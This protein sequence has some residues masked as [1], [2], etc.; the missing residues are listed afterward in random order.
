MQGMIGS[1]NIV[2]KMTKSR[3]SFYRQYLLEDIGEDSSSDEG[4]VEKLINDEIRLIGMRRHLRKKRHRIIFRNPNGLWF[5]ASITFDWPDPKT[6]TWYK[7]YVLSDSFGKIPRLMRKF[8]KRFNLPI[9]Q[10]LELVQLA[11]DE[12]WFPNAEKRDCTGQ[13]GHPLELMVLGSL[14]YFFS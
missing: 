2:T 4:S 10:L 1:N 3:K 5:N 14:Q 8:Q 6:S 7:L 11:R 12:H 9:E 13:M